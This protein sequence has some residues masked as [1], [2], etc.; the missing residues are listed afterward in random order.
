MEE[1]YIFKKLKT[2]IA[3]GGAGL[4]AIGIQFGDAPMVVPISALISEAWK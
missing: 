1:S 3:D 4:I 2:A